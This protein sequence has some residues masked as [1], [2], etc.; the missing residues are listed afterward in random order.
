MKVNF[1]NICWNYYWNRLKNYWLLSYLIFIFICCHNLFLFLIQ[2][3]KD[4]DKYLEVFLYFKNNVQELDIAGNETYFSET[5]KV[6]TF[7][8]QVFNFDWDIIPSGSCCRK[9]IMI[10][11]VVLF[12]NLACERSKIC[13]VTDE[14]IR[15]TTLNSE[16]YIWI[17]GNFSF[18]IWTCT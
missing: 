14:K 16:N 8:D 5:S 2:K 17:V 9:N 13:H 6:D 15:F 11:K 1:F 10:D 18:I 12:I 7:F 4:S 3:T